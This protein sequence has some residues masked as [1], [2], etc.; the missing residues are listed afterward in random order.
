MVHGYIRQLGWRR[1]LTISFPSANT[2]VRVYSENWLSGLWE[3]CC[4]N[5]LCHLTI[6][7]CLVMR[8]YRGDCCCQTD[9]AEGDIRSFFRIQYA[10]LQ[11]FAAIQ[12]RLWCPGFSGAAFA[13]EL[14]RDVF[15]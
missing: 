15:W 11:V 3:N 7:P 9:H 8:I 6:V 14:M 1:G 10:P 12:Q 4:C 5:L 2:T 13:M